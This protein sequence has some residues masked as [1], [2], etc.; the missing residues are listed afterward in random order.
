MTVTFKNKSLPIFLSA[1]TLI[2]LLAFG[3]SSF[4]KSI[5]QTDNIKPE[6]EV[7]TIDTFSTFP[8]EID[9]CSCYFSN[10]SLEFN[11]SEYIYLNDFAQTSFIKI[12]GVLTKFTQTDIIEV[13][14]TSTV[15]KAKSDKY[16]M[17]IEFSND[18]QSGDETS[19]KSGAIKLTNKNGKTIT[20][21]FYGECGC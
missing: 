8:P 13:S 1:V 21:I 3:Q 11:K 17:T 10:D 5:S 9:G 4:N 6:E 12:N 2:F 16:E 20:K 14:K 7:F 19:L 18:K 15:A